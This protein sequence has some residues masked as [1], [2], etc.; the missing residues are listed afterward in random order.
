MNKSPCVRFAPSPTGKLHL[1][2]A[3]TA[4][5][6]WLY[7]KH[8]GG[9][10]FLRIE[11]TDTERSKQEYTDQILNS[12]E[13]L[14]LKWSEPLIYQSKRNLIYKEEVQKLLDN[15]R[16]YRCFLTKEELQV[17]R[18]KAK[19]EGGEF[20]VPKTYRDLS[21]DDQKGLINS[22][23]SFTIRLKIPSKGST[24]FE[25]KIY[26]KINVN[27]KV[28]DDFIIVRSD[29][30]PTYNFTVVVDDNNMGIN[31][32]IRGEDHISNTPKQ[33]LIYSALN[34]PVPDF[35]HL[36]MILGSDKK[37]LSKRH[38]AAA[39][40]DFREQGYSVDALLNYIAMLGWNSDSEDELF[41]LEDLISKFDIN[42]IQK[43]GAVYD[44][45]KLH[46]V[47]GQHMIRKS[48]KNLLN[49]IREDDPNWQKHSKD[50]YIFSVLKLMKIRAKTLNELKEVCAYF[51][52]DPKDFD[53]NAIIKRWKDKSVNKLINNFITRLEKL[54]NWSQKDLDESLRDTAQEMAVSAAKLIHPVRL[55]V[56]GQSHGPGLF[57]LIELLGKMTTLRRLRKAL[58]IFPLKD[59]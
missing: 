31:Y 19:K 38:G 13:W 52:S 53:E 43:K 41:S 21:L 12:L 28:I 55:A 14:G 27:N 3:R 45:K 11:D 34:Y 24:F 25:D 51:F 56:S 58:D 23:Q 4:L 42:K 54:S 50:T 48:E 32:V 2:G 1:G 16:A 59:D 7:A 47:A 20:R 36:P 29:G 57:E 49:E 10:F 39:V 9:N 46:W 8:N 37:R 35:A 6:N 44:E 5:F 18:E 15:G 30:S 33:I 40:E 17:A 26:G 22:G